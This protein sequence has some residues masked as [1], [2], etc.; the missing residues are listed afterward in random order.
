MEILSPAGDFN[1][2]I[3][4]VQ[5]GADA[6]YVGGSNFSARKSAKNFDDDELKKA[7]DY[8]HLRDVKLYVACNTLMKEN[9]LKDAFSFLETIYKN[10]AD[11]VIVQDLGLSRLLSEYLPE[12]PLHIS[13]QMTVTSADGVNVLAEK[14]GAKRVVLARELSFS[15]IKKIKEETKAELEVFCHGALGMSYS[16]QC[17]F[18]SVIG[19]RSGNRGGCAQPCRLS[20][21]LCENGKKV[22]KDITL[23]SPKDLCLAEEI[24][25]LKEIRVDSLKIEGRMKSPEYVAAATRVYSEALKNKADKKEIEKMLSLFS[26]AGSGKG[27]F[28]GRTFDKMMSYSSGGKI[29]ADKETKKE[30]KETYRLE[31]KKTPISMFFKGETGKHMIL[32]IFDSVGRSITLEGEKM[33]V[34]ENKGTEPERIKAQLKKLGG[35][36]FEAEF[37]EVLTDGGAV[38]IKDINNLRRTAIEK[39]EREICES[40]YR[41]PEKI[42]YENKEV[43]EEKDIQISVEVT[44]KEQYDVLK[45][46]DEIELFVPYNLYKEVNPKNAVCIL[47]PILKD[48]DIPDLTGISKIEINN[49]GQLDLSKGK[50]LY[51]GYSMNITNSAS[52]KT[53]KNFGAKRLCFST[54]L[55]LNE[56]KKAIVKN[57]E[58]E[59][60]VYGRQRLMYMENCVIKSAYGCKCNEESFSL[61][62]RLGV[63]FPI[64]MENCRNIIL[65]SRPVYMADKFDDIKRLGIDSIRLIF[66]L[67]NK[68]ECVEIVNEYKKALS[69]KQVNGFKG[70][71]TRGH[72]YRGAK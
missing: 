70:E 36:P 24:E 20:Y 16:G 10:G 4:A 71:F 21:S 64:I 31:H 61:C 8:C 55:A 25:K 48:K 27:Y 42:I 51:T 53:L 47:P 23:L 65:N 3:A 63:E 22:T 49:I 9:E 13:T 35:T 59:C 39:L 60:V 72:F 46:V 30:V 58:T 37:V 34:P 50:E 66:T 38:S 5:N 29:S 44:T 2:L 67:E 26:R 17:L 40:F 45:G 43:K 12:M 69:G 15:E 18:S 41:N 62:D 54:E 57:I 19:G 56:I 7:I 33:V 28:Y 68:K 11:A 6:V 1:S 14:F 32:T 52:V